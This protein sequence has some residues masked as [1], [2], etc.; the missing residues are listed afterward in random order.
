MTAKNKITVEEAIALLRSGG[1]LSRRVITNLDVSKVKAI[2]ALLLAESGLVVPDGNIVYD[3]NDIRYDPDFDDIDW[4]EPT[5]FR[6]GKEQFSSGTTEKESKVEELA[7][8]VFVKN[9]AMREWIAVNR[10]KLDVLISKL[11]EDLY[12][13]E[14]IT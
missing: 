7:V 10:K 8:K 13:T 1:D 2:D 12:K 4:G 9:D 5:P 11:L 6:K 14:E 3:D